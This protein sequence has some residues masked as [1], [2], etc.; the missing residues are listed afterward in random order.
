[1]INSN[2]TRYMILQIFNTLEPYYITLLVVVGLIGNSISL[3]LFLSTKLRSRESHIILSALAVVDNGFLI[4]LFIVNLKH[5][6]FDLFNNNRIVCKSTVYFAYVFSFLSI[7]YVV[8]FSLERLIAVCFP[9]RRYD[10]CSSFRNKIVIFVL[11]LFSLLFY[12]FTIF[13]SGIETDNGTKA[14]VTKAYWI[15]FVKKFSFI[16]IWIT[17]IIPFFIILIVNASISVKLMMVIRSTKTFNTIIFFNR[18]RPNSPIGIR[19]KCGSLKSYGTVRH[20]MARASTMGL[21]SVKYKRRLSKKYSKTTRV[22]LTISITYV[23][24]NIFMAY[25]KIRYCFETEF[26]ET[27]NH[28]KVKNFGQQN[29]NSTHSPDMRIKPVEFNY[30]WEDQFYERISCQNLR[31]LYRAL[32]IEIVIERDLIKE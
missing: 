7:W 22:L 32:E 16:D 30:D 27:L 13:T 19:K 28:E 23:L 14:C 21:C 12:S 5:F 29:E 2:D 8:L 26:F 15:S 4:S 18:N 24:L 17:I 10:L 3:T 1:M 31:S 25:S 20:S 6:Q 11:V 9:L